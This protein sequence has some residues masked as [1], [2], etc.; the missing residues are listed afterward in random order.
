MKINILITA[1]LIASST[2]SLQAMAPQVLKTP[3]GHR[4]PITDTIIKAVVNSSNLEQ[5]CKDIRTLTRT[6][7]ELRTLLNTPY[8][9]TV[10]IK[11]LAANH[12]NGK[13]VIV[14]EELKTHGA[15]QALYDN[16]HLVNPNEL[17]TAKRDST[18]FL[19]LLPEEIF[20]VILNQTTHDLSFEK[21][22]EFFSSNPALVK[23]NFRLLYFVAQKSSLFKANVQAA[24]IATAQL[25][26]TKPS[27]Q[28]ANSIK[29][30]SYDAAEADFFI[31]KMAIEKKDHNKAKDLLTKLTPHPTSNPVFCAAAQ[32]ELA[33]LYIS[34]KI[35]TKFSQEYAKECARAAVKQS[36]NWTVREEAK[37]FCQQNN[38]PY[39][40]LLQGQNAISQQEKDLDPT[41]LTYA[42][43]YN[44]GGNF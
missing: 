3:D 42:Q 40:D 22:L 5:A 32:L 11:E 44:G 13:A 1:I 7:K 4:A 38:I 20:R 39:R 37:E 8:N 18:G 25:L 17:L 14:A 30:K 2:L 43:R 9:T 35:D 6:S 26:N 16:H 41:R 34:Q 28:W 24:L 12:T 10:L 33:K 29:P 15:A 36:I 23:D 31:A 21:L 19:S 27:K